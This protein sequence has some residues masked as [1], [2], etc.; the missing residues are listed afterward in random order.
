MAR[1]PLEL[2][3]TIENTAKNAESF[4]RRE[5]DKYFDQPG[6]Y[7][8]LSGLIDVTSEQYHLRDDEK[9]WLKGRLG[10]YINKNVGLFHE[11]WNK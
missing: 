2:A 8:G 6:T 1:N 5:L 9:E 7:G 10:D 4:A 3:K 11:G